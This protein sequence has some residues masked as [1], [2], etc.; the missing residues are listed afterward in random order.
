MLYCLYHGRCIAARCNQRPVFISVYV[1][2]IDNPN[3]WKNMV[4][5]DFH[6]PILPEKDVCH[7]VFVLIPMFDK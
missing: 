1:M 5:L 3:N 2:I 6:R 7:F 4:R